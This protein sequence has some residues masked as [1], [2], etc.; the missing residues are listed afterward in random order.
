[1]ETRVVC[2]MGA[3]HT[4]RRLFHCSCGGAVS[5]SSAVTLAPAMPYAALLKLRRQPHEEVARR[6][7]SRE[8]IGSLAEMIGF[9]SGTA[10]DTF[11]ST[12]DTCNTPLRFMTG[13][14]LCPTGLP[15]QWNA[16]HL[17]LQTA[18]ATTPWGVRPLSAAANSA[19]SLGVSVCCDS[20]T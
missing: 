7:V 19:W 11:R 9:P 5:G 2:G 4:T 14:S 18:I 16:L 8:L 1:M 17:V 12:R 13:S 6:V 15:L 10:T 3:I 20:Q